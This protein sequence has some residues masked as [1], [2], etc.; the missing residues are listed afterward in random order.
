MKCICNNIVGTGGAEKDE[1]VKEQIPREPIV[2]GNIEYNMS[3]ED[4]SLSQMKNGFLKCSSKN[5]S[6]EFEFVEV[7]LV[8]GQKRKCSKSK[9]LNAKCRKKRRTQRKKILNKR[10]RT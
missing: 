6:L 8:G 4:I 7:P 5:G 9:K 2:E 3:E 1:L 10:K